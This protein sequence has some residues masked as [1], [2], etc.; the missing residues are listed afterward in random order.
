MTLSPQGKRGRSIH[1]RAP[2]DSHVGRAC[3]DCNGSTICIYHEQKTSAWQWCSEDTYSI[4]NG[5]IFHMPWKEATP[6]QWHSYRRYGQV[7]V[8]RTPPVMSHQML[9]WQGFCKHLERYHSRQ[10]VVKCVSLWTCAC[11]IGTHLN[12]DLCLLLKMASCYNSRNHNYPKP[13]L[14]PFCRQMSW[15]G[16]LRRKRCRSVHE[17]AQ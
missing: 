16:I 3:S 6:P 9:D 7:Q 12:L 13:P 8:G 2:R 11:T 4:R 5:Y 15:K 10:G 14:L 17:V 1:Q